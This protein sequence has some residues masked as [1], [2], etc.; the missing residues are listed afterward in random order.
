MPLKSTGEDAYFVAS[1]SCTGFFCYYRQCFDDERITRVYVIKGGPGTGK[2]YFMRE[3][4]DAARSCGWRDERIYCSSDANSLD[5]VILTKGEAGIAL[6]DGTLPHTYEPQL[7]GVREEIINLGDFWNSEALLLQK[8]EIRAHNEEKKRAYQMA[9]RYLAGYG[10]VQKNRDD[11]ISP[12]IRMEAMEQYAARIMEDAG[13]GDGFFAAP[14]LMRSVGMGGEVCLDTY[15]LQATQIFTVEDCRGCAQYFMR[16]LC[17]EMERR[18][19]RIRV[20]Y[21]PVLPDRIDGLHLM[22]RGWSFVVGR[23][24]E[25]P[26]PHKRLG[27]RRFVEMGKLKPIRPMLNHAEQMSRALR[28]GA[29]EA[30]AAVRAAHMKLEQI[31]A[32]AMDFTAKEAFTKS[33]CERIFHLKNGTQCG[34]I[35]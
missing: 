18:R 25:C 34:T 26:F 35:E 4:A 17:R 16:M 22:D 3:V 28:G 7:P 27:L 6:L 9:Y 31:Y 14:A 8:E 32:S 11:L 19:L 2:S 30:M 24:E 12:Y 29:I 23:E 20:S 1:N 5:A 33:F 10:E 15:F 13:Y 21:D